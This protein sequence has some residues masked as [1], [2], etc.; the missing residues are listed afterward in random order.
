MSRNHLTAEQIDAILPQTQCGLCGYGGCMPYAEGLIRENAAIDLCPP[1][2][3]KGLQ[4]IA[5]LVNED[6]TPFIAEMEKKAKPK[7]LAV[8]REAECIGCTKC[9]QACPVDAIIGSGKLMHT[10]I[11]DECTGCELC[12]AP[13][14]VDCIDMITIPESIEAEDQRKA[15]IARERFQ[16]RNQRL[17]KAANEIIPSP[18]IATLI[19]TPIDDK[20][21]LL[22]AA[23][24]RAKMKKNQAQ[25]KR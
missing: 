3:L 24:L 20:K 4:A 10:V 11:A 6:A 5:E 23:L 14:P 15:N 17:A 22:E 7:L 13:C 21:A 9:I 8:I 19:P 12:V 25:L 16:A 1:G 2:G 18:V